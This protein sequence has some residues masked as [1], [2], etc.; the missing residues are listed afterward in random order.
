MKSS[1]AENDNLIDRTIELW[2]PRL[3]RDLTREDA[4]QI[5]ENAAGF[6]TIL[7]EWLQ[8]EMSTQAH[9][10]S[11]QPETIGGEVTQ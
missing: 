9:D 4:R 2:Q 10:A 8:A 11:K 5:V 6:F 3:Q 1:S 7:A